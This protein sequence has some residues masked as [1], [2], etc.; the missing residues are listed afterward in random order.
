MSVRIESL[1]TA[2]YTVP[3]EGGPESDGTLVWDSTT[4][5]VVEAAGGGER[6]LGFSYTHRAAA[7]LVDDLLAPLVTG[8]DALAPGAAFARMRE[9]TRNLG[10][11]GLAACAVSAVDV[12]L[13]DLKTRL[14]ET[15]L[16]DL[17]GPVREAVPVYGSGGFTSLSVE[18]LG[19]QLAGW[20]AAG[21]PRVKMKIG[22][23][24]ADDPARVAAAR[25]A[26]GPEAELFVDANG[27]Y[28][29][30]QALA[31]A[32]RFAADGVSWFEEPVLSDDVDGLRWLRDR[33]PAG[34]EIAAGEYGWRLVDFER[35][36]AAGAVD[37]LQPDAT[38]CG[39]VT[40]FLAAAGLCTAHH[41]PAS[42]H[43]APAL[44]AHL[45]CACPPVRHVECFHDHVRIERMFF[46]G[47]PELVDGALRPDRSRPGHGLELR[48][49]DVER[50]RM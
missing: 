38:R 19:E 10:Q 29:R 32:E 49:A 7:L 17:L 4:M 23:Q 33:A 1:T 47:L 35:L 22:R 2:A 42:A 13:W 25:R 43:T 36:L 12:A 14:L 48:R 39:G 11:P 16:V 8:G 15:S 20:I 24:P 31:M 18:A 45:G 26:I 34:V 27:A 28:T 9:A 40:G 21:I 44:H 5:V 46:D 37:V 3:T 6:G 50:W 30:R 41:T